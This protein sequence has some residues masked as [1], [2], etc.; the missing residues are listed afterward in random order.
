M[1]ANKVLMF[2]LVLCMVFVIAACSNGNTPIENAGSSDQ[3]ASGEKA[4]DAETPAKDVTIKVF[5]FKVGPFVDA[6]TELAG[7]YEKET[8]VKVEIETHGGGADYGAMLKA[9]IASGSEP[10]IYNNGGFSSLTEYMDRTVELT[11]QPWVSNLIEVTK[12]NTT[13][14]GKLYGMPMNTEGY[15]IIY[16]KDLFA[17]AGITTEPRTL[18]ELKDAVS[19][20]QEAGITP[21]SATNEWWSLGIH[22]VNIAVA[23]QPD[24]AQFVADLVEGRTTIKGNGVFEEWLD[25]IDLIFENAQGN[26]LTT[27]FTTQ[28]AHFAMGEAAMLPQGNWMQP[29]LD[30][31]DPNLNM[32]VLPYS[33]NDQP[34]HVFMGVPNNWIVN[35]KS[36]HPE[37]ALAFL[38]WMVN[39]DEGKTYMTREF[40][41]MP[42]FNNI[43]APKEEIGVLAAAIIEQSDRSLGWHWDR[44]PN[45]VTQ[46]F[47]A[48]MQEYQGK[49]ITREQLL[50]KLDK[51]VKDILN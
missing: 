16:N 18:P 42:A 39:S 11:D 30:A 47:G 44:F 41:F 31:I 26:M 14:D 20:L 43:D 6:F 2:L 51:A 17:K 28:V 50:E 3:P 21:F 49:Q 36:E 4:A 45:G 27:D 10:E 37:E 40:Q 24:P 8:G 29:D 46:G 15:G 1:K 35:S 12:A 23:N 22:L 9:E 19:K 33:I 32:G 13:V 48:A 7:I 34:G 38:D 5:Q 25:L